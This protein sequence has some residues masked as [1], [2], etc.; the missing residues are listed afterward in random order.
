[1]PPWSPERIRDDDAQFQPQPRPNYGGDFRG[2]AIGRFGQQQHAVLTWIELRPQIRGIDARVGH[3][4][5]QFVPRY[6]HARRRTHHGGA[7]T[8]GQFD[9]SRVLAGR[10]RDLPSMR[11]WVYRCQRNPA[12]FRLGDDLLRNYQHITRR[13]TSGCKRIGQQRTQVAPARDFADP[14]ERADLDDRARLRMHG[15]A[16][17]LRGGVCR[18]AARAVNRNRRL[19]A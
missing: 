3:D 8:Q 4:Q 14:D 11:T 9:Q 10:L 12:P 16:F 7:F 6:Q 5:P 17:A 19:P 18:V 15:G 13:G 1:M 2:R